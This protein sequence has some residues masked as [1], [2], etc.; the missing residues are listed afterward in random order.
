[1]PMDDR[2]KILVVDDEAVIRELLSDVLSDEGYAVECA[3][4]AREALALLR[5]VDGFFLLFTDVMMP[6]M[7]GIE[8]VREA[9]KIRPDLIPIVMTGFA[10][11]ESAR[12]AVKE[13]AYDYILKPFSLSDIKLAV[14]NAV[15][16]YRLTRE[17]VRL[18][19]ITELFNISERIAA[20]H[21]EHALYDFVLK[22]AMERVAA[23]RG[24]LMLVTPDR[25]GLRVVASVGVPDDASQ[26]VVEL[27]K[28]ISGWVAEHVSP[29][30]V[31]NIRQTLRM[32]LG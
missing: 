21:D 3:A 5:E 32:W 13:G 2:G 22:A 24:S 18:R 4:N 16:R 19:E 30:L 6:E 17:N 14:T 31:E 20:I 27:G 26:S 8:L 23:E 12:G 11:L 15:E 9:R 7:D 28:G 25:K 1:M 10:S 29:L